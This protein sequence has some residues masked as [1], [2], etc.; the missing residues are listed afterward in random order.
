[1]LQAQQQSQNEDFKMLIYNFVTGKRYGQKVTAELEKICK[2]NGYKLGLFATS[3]Q[4]KQN[5]ALF[6]AKGQ[7]AHKVPMYID[8]RET[9]F[10]LFN[11]AQCVITGI[12]KKLK[13]KVIYIEK[14]LISKPKQ[15]TTQEINEL[16]Q[17]LDKF[18]ILNGNGSRCRLYLD[19]EENQTPKFNYQ[20]YKARKLAKIQEYER[21]IKELEAELQTTPKVANAY[22]YG[23]LQVEN[24]PF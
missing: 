21:R 6:V 3:Q 4:M 17:A 5:S 19:S 24:C 16:L 13:T 7:K 18:V 20:E 15:A 10:C 14:P 23:D 8:G 12:E 9:Y 22:G 2:D 1:M 11:I